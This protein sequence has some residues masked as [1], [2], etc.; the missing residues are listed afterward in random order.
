MTNEQNTMTLRL[1]ANTGSIK[2]D[3][4]EYGVNFSERTKKGESSDRD[5]VAFL[6]RQ[7]LGFPAK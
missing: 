5:R 4:H 3:D 6:M 1:G 2:W 7:R